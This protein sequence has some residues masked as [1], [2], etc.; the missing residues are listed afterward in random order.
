MQPARGGELA[1]SV[2]LMP[3]ILRPCGVE[4]PAGLPGSDLLDAEARGQRDAIFGVS[5]S[6]HNMIPGDPA[7]GG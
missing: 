1:S 5:Y 2:D 3:T 7:P 4:P 6:I